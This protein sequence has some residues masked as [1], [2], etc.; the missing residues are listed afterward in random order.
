MLLLL[1]A[2]AL[3]LAIEVPGLLAR[4]ERRELWVFAVLLGLGTLLA[5][6]VIQEWPLPN[7]ADVTRAYLGPIH[8]KLGLLSP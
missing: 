5:L 1:L 7:P 2:V 3:L 6:G 8:A 4:G